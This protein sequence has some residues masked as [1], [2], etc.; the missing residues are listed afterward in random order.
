MSEQTPH[1]PQDAVPST[2]AEFT[3]CF[4]ALKGRC[5]LLGLHDS[6]AAALIA[7]LLPEATAPFCVLA[8][9]H[10]AAER[11]FEDLAFHA[12]GRE[13]LYFFPH[14]GI[15]PF[16]PLNP[17]LEL[18]ATRIVSL[19]ALLK[20]KARAVVLPVRALMQRLIPQKTLAELCLTL[21]PGDEFDRTRLLSLLVR[22]GYSAAP[23]VEE[24][25]TFSMRGDILD[26]FPPT[27]ANPARIDFF[28]DEVERI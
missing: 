14:W 25:G 8:P 3:G 17:H 6:A 7:R 4:P 24:R 1:F 10:Q 9:D 13:G 21:R 11:F 26:L 19:A 12:G 20:G 27:T 23:L 15:N 2:L 16:E 18:E 22:L 5:E 28:G